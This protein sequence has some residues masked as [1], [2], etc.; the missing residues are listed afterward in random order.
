MKPWTIVTAL[1][2]ITFLFLGGVV[3]LNHIEEVER[4]EQYHATHCYWN[5]FGDREIELRDR[6]YGMNGIE[7]YNVSNDCL[8]EIQILSYNNTTGVL[9]YEM[10]VQAVERFPVRVQV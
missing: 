3:A 7:H 9:E 8:P 10:V 4:Q 6:A 5:P 1:V 2:I